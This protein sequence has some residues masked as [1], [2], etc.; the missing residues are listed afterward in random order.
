MVC[1]N[2]EKKII[3]INI[4]KTGGQSIEKILIENF[5]F[6]Y[7]TFDDNGQDGYAYEFLTKD[8]GKEG[9]FKYILTYS[10]ESKIYDLIS[11]RKFTFV[12]H[13]H[14]RAFSGIR[15][16]YQKSSLDFPNNL[17]DFYQ[18]C[19][20]TPV[21]YIHFNMSQSTCLK[22][23]DGNISMDYIGKFEN[24]QEDLDH[25]LFDIFK[26]ENRNIIRT[27]VHKTDQSLIYFDKEIIK[28]I[29]NIEHKEDFER[30]GYSIC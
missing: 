11:F 24:Y 29:V 20:N 1:F 19:L 3:F 14:S 25:V 27:H 13:P 18:K 12:R 4:P 28:E 26:F 10:K 6:K 22:D 2:L 7:F 17:Y 30:F 21:F 15:F 8:E 5:N 9:Y 23:L 16:L